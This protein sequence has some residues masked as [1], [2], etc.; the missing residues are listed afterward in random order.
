NQAGRARCCYCPA[1]SSQVSRGRWDTAGSTTACTGP[2]GCGS[3]K[4]RPGT[5][6]ICPDPL[7][8]RTAELQNCRTAELLKA[9]GERRRAKGEGRT[10]S[11]CAQSGLLIS[12][13]WKQ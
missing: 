2:S 10:A 8:C 5:F 1:Y 6:G 12:H 9:K 11:C 4:R 13:G 7:N 3:L